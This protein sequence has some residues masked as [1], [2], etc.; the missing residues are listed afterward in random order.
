MIRAYIEGQFVDG[1]G[2]TGGLSYRWSDS[3]VKQGQE[4]AAY[5]PADDYAYSRQYDSHVAESRQ[6]AYRR[7]SGY[8]NAS[9]YYN[10]VKEQIAEYASRGDV[11]TSGKVYIDFTITSDGRV[12][13]AYAYSDD[14]ELQDFARETVINAA[15]YP[16][17]PEF[18][19]KD[20]ISFNSAIVF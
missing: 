7:T 12:K 16:R 3:R 8:D 5:K 1:I 9:D 18:L 20:E 4:G 15:P 19:N 17:I 11:S 2:V 6:D 13:E 14:P 10:A